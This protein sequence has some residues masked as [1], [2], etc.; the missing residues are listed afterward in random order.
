M[1]HRFCPRIRSAQLRAGRA[2][3]AAAGMRRRSA[4]PQVAHRRR[5]LR[6]PGHRAREEQ[7]FER[8]LALEDIALGQP[9]VA[10]EVERRQHLPVQDDVADVRRVL[11]DRV[12]DRVA[13]RLAL[14]VP[15]ARRQLVRRVLHE[16]REDVLARRR[17]RRIGQRRDH[18]VHVRPP[19]E[20]AVLR[21]VV[22]ALHVVDARAR[23]RSRRAGA[24]RRPA[25]T[26]K[27]GQR[28]EREVH[29]ARRAAVLVAPHLV[30]ESRPAAPSRR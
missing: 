29:L 3:D 27:F 15:G 8:Q 7:L 18:H 5:V 22:G 24:A 6:P 4:H 19:R 26:V 11:G 2:H 14:V 25:C 20:L 12:D 21:L 23:S 16:A 17:D 10:L 30:D 13:E 1:R 28:V 9:E